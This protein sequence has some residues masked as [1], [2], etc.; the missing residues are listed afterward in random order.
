MTTDAEKKALENAINSLTRMQSFDVGTL[1][2]EAELGKSYSFHNAVEPATRIVELFKRLSPEALDDFGATQLNQLQDQADACFNLFESVLAF[3]AK[4]G[5]AHDVQQKLIQQI[6]AAYQGAFNVLLPLVGYSLHKSA[7]FQRLDSEARAALQKIKDEANEITGSLEQQQTDAEGALEAIRTV[8]AEQGVTQQAIYF[9]DEAD[10]NTTDA[11]TWRERTI[12]I[13]WWLGG[14]AV[15]SLG[16]HKIPFIAPMNTYET[17]QMAISKI[18][19][20]AVIS[21]VLYL[22]AKNFLSHKH[23]AVVNR[24]R[25]NALMTYKALVEAAGEKQQ[26]SDA[27]LVHAA[28]CIYAPQPTG[29]SPSGDGSGQGAK[30]VI[31]LLSK[32]VT[33]SSD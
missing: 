25:Q 19:I 26:A 27:V 3:D 16:I 28:S 10:Q 14:Y 7:D 8:A 22:S 20:F 30:S 29:Y 21:F 2:R 18:L 6:E 17:V 12:K 5:N 13:A 15:L 33:P 1:P 9:K 23:N 24:H 31:E 4:Q 32:P 11:E